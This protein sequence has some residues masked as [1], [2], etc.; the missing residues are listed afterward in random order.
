MNNQTENIEI[1]LDP[2]VEAYE[3]ATDINLAE[4]VLCDVALKA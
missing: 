4:K 3:K 2:L 1:V